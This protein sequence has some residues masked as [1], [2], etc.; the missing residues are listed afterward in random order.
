MNTPRA[1]R[2]ATLYRFAAP[3]VSLDVSP[4]AALRTSVCRHVPTMPYFAVQTDVVQSAPWLRTGT[5]ESTGRPCGTRAVSAGR[6]AK[7]AASRRPLVSSRGRALNPR[8]L[9]GLRTSPGPAET[10]D[11]RD[12][13]RHDWTY[14]RLSTFVQARLGF[15]D[16]CIAPRRY[17]SGRGSSSGG[18]GLYPW[19]LGSS[20]YRGVGPVTCL[21]SP[22][23]PSRMT[24]T[25]PPLWSANVHTAQSP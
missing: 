6:K 1:S 8:P 24:L 23:S 25:L 12:T 4:N 20:G 21:T 19:T 16:R 13:L 15:R 10:L 22:V 14:L 11:A 2:Y 17:S 5:Q 3:A 7:G 18:G 9:G